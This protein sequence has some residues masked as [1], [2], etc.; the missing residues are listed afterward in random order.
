MTI[1]EFQHLIEKIYYEKD[2]KRGVERTFLWFAEEVGELA[3]AIREKKD[4]S[5]LLGEFSDTF[6]WLAGLASLVN[7][8]LEKAASDYLKGCPDCQK[9][10]CECSEP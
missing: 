9:L 10:P 8:D 5:K 1:S 3:G 6:A 7:I 4:K 2:A